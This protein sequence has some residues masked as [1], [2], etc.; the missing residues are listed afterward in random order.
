MTFRFHQFFV[1]IAASLLLITSSCND[2]GAKDA[3]I[4]REKMQ[5]LLLDINIAE[6]YSSM[7]KDTLHKPGTKNADSL[8]A[9]YTDI[10]AHH[11]VTRDEFERAMVW[12]KAHPD[13]MDSLVNGIMP[14]VERMQS[15]K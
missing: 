1:A 11:Q 13:E 3:P 9:F 4:P 8:T 2:K 10:F 7:T 15:G 6:V 12:Y 14:V 5:K